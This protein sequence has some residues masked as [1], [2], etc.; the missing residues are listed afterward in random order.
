MHVM[1]YRTDGEL[2][3]RDA[4]RSKFEM[5]EFVWVFLF[6]VGFLGVAASVLCQGI[7]KCV[8]INRYIKSN[9][10]THFKNMAYR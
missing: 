10:L 4:C 5:P 6:F 9:L 8:L 1:F 3:Y 2:C 7:S